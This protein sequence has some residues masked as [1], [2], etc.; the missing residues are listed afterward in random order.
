[1]LCEFRGN[2]IRREA[3]SGCRGQIQIKVFTCSKH[4]ECTIAKQISG[5][6]VCDEKPIRKPRKTIT[7]AVVPLSREGITERQSAIVAERLIAAAP[8]AMVRLDSGEV[9]AA[10][11]E[12]RKQKHAGCR[13]VVGKR[14]GQWILLQ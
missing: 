4:G 1:M 11:N 10:D 13:C 9:I 8:F 6:H 14:E 2:E 5:V 7:Q 3:C 12:R